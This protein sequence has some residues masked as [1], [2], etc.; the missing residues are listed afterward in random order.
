M[1]LEDGGSAGSS[2]HPNG[3]QGSMKG[4]KRVHVSRSLENIDYFEADDEENNHDKAVGQPSD[5]F[6]QSRSIGGEKKQTAFQDEDFV[7]D[8]EGEQ[9]PEDNM[10]GFP[11]PMSNALAPKKMGTLEGF[12]AVANDSLAKTDAAAKKRM[13]YSRSESSNDVGEVQFEKK[14]SQFESGHKRENTKNFFTET[15]YQVGSAVMQN[16]GGEINAFD[17]EEKQDDAE[18]KS[19]VNPDSN[20]RKLN[21][22]KQRIRKVQ[23]VFSRVFYKFPDKRPHLEEYYLTKVSSMYASN[24]VTSVIIY[25]AFR[26]LGSLMTIRMQSKNVANL[27]F[28]SSEIVIIMGLSILV[29]KKLIVRKPEMVKKVMLAVVYVE[30]ITHSLRLYYE[31]EES[32]IHR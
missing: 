10:F 21:W 8:S 23:R 3:T 19:S 6:K 11:S 29:S 16:I 1:S 13:K 30:F 31:H 12:S 25:M 7:D 28:W 27:I 18:G 15:E 24:F 2:K 4:G 17:E 22:L 14:E 32:N 20:K 9:A 26:V 5:S